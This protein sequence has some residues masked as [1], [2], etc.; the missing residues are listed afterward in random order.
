MD[1]LLLTDEESKK[2]F[3]EEWRVDFREPLPSCAARQA[4]AKAQVLKIKNSEKYRR[5]K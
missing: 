2:A 1:E 4:I 3:E 5:K